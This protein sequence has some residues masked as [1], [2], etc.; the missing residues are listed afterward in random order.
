MKKNYNYNYVN[1]TTKPK[2]DI[3]FS[4]VE[5]ASCLSSVLKKS[6]VVDGRLW[7][8]TDTNEFFYDWNGKR[9]KLNV[10]GD[11]ASLLAEINKLKSDV[12]KLNPEKLD[13]LEVKVNNAVTKVNNVSTRVNNAV[14]QAQSASQLAED[15]AAQVAN[16][17]NASDLAT[18]ATTGKYSDLKNKPTIPSKTSQLTNDSGFLTEHQSLTDYAKKTDLNSYA[19][20][21][22]IPDVSDFA[23]KSEIP[24][25]EGLASESWVEGKGYLTQ[26]QDISG[27]AD[28]SELFSGDY[29]DLT[30]KPTIPSVPTKVSDLTNDAGYI[31]VDDLPEGL[32][33]S[34]LEDYAKKSDIPTVPTKVSDL[35]ND[36]GYIT[37]TNLR[38]PAEWNVNGSMIDLIDDINDDITATPGK[39]Y[40]GTIHLNDLPYS[41]DESWSGRRLVQGEARI[42]IMASQGDTGKVINFTLT[43]TLKPYHWEYTSSWRNEGEW[44]SFLTSHQDISGKADKSELPSK[45]SDLSNDAGYITAADLPEYLTDSDLPDVTEGSFPTGDANIENASAAADGLA[46][47]QDVMDYVRAYFEKK[48]DEIEPDGSEVPVAIPYLY[49]NGYRRGDTATE[50]TDPLNAYEI[51]LDGNGNFEIELLHKDEESGVYVEGDPDSTYLGEYFKVVI[52]SDYEIKLY[53]WDDANNVYKANDT[54]VTD[55]AYELVADLVTPESTVYYYRSTIEGFFID[56]CNV[57][58]PYINA[59]GHLVKA[60]I[61]K[62]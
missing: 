25:V 49:T 20:K 17:V 61:R 48:K 3:E 15:A 9:N 60:V 18:V 38:I 13:Q 40:L 11:N 53:F 26:H 1:R 56:G 39:V 42:E 59:Y 44:I 54:S 35:T 51:V 28:K 12:A 7:H 34:D 30:N 16:K 58:E 21:T 22:E 47:V 27:K 41:E 37:S 52:P 31:T 45:V 8:T 46:T 23:T 43:S 6:P 10:T 57:V 32:S 55:P 33:D 19:K 29:N 5:S 50:L 2:T 62:K 14:S 4:N 24:S 36:E